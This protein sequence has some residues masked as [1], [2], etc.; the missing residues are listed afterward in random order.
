MAVVTKMMIRREITKRAL[1]ARDTD[2]IT[3]GMLLA[4]LLLFFIVMATG[5]ICSCVLCRKRR[6]LESDRKL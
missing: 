5:G 4:L 2:D 3:T 1:E 6:K